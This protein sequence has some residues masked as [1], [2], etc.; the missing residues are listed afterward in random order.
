MLKPNFECRQLQQIIVVQGVYGPGL[1]L[2]SPTN[3]Y[4]LKMLKNQNKYRCNWPM[5]VLFHFFKKMRLLFV[6][7]RFLMVRKIELLKVT[8]AQ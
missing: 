6:I 1:L 7:G 3:V 8:S 5:R 4:S 2:N